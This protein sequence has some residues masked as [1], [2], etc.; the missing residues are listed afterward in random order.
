MIPNRIASRWI[1]TAVALMMAPDSPLVA[2]EKKSDGQR[3]SN[4]GHMIGNTTLD[5]WIADPC[6]PDLIDRHAAAL[7]TD[8]E[9]QYWISKVSR[10]LL[11]GAEP[12]PETRAAMA[13]RSRE[14]IVQTLLADPRFGDTVLDFNL[15]FL[16]FKRDS[17]RDD[18]G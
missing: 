10:K 16:G 7:E 3:L 9:K 5:A 13:G 14:D 6:R 15:Y 2:Q 4:R 11:A 18:T 1:A 8:W 12:D 17:V